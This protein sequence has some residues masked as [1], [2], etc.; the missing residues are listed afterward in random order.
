MEKVV[1]DSSE[2]LS[3]A[4]EQ[5]KKNGLALA[6]ISFVIMIIQSAISGSGYDYSAILTAMK[7]NDALALQNLMGGNSAMGDLSWVVYAVLM[8]GFNRM[9]LLIVTGVKSAP[10]FD[11]Y[12]MDIA[13]W[14]KIIAVEFIV[15]IICACGFCLCI[16]PGIYLMARLEWASYYLM[17]NNEAGIG[18]ALSA[19][20]NMSSNN[21]MEL[22][23]VGIIAFFVSI[24][25]L[26]LCCIG[27]YYT[28]V[29]AAY[30]QVITYLKLKGNL[31]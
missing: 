13:V 26:L 11:A 29:V 7:E 10:S 3:S 19:S 9:I 8:I 23:L 2:I 5:A 12:K 20:W 22:I 21:A 30:M 1:I 14:A 18:E 24:A 6:V 15:G 16:L 28:T 4:W 25:G 17:E 31:E 27:V